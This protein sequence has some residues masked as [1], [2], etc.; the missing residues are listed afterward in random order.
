VLA[1]AIALYLSQTVEAQPTDDVGPGKAIRF[2]GVDDYIDLGDV[3][4][5]LALP[6]T[7]SVWVN[8][9][10]GSAYAYP[11][12]NSQDNLPLYNGVTFL[13]SAQGISI[14]Y[15][16]GRGEN[17]PSFRRGKSATIPDIA[18]RWVNLTAVM[19]GYYDMELFLNGVNVGGQYSGS[20][21]YPMASASPG[22]DAKIGYWLSNGIVSHFKGLMDDLRVF[23]RALSELEVKEQMCRKLTGN[24]SGLIGYWNFNELG[25]SYAK[26]NSPNGFDGQFQGNPTRV[27]SGAAIG[28]E[29][30]FLY[31][32]SWTGN[33]LEFGDIIVN[34]VTGSPEGI[35]IY[36]V[37]DIPS[38]TN[39]LDLG[40]IKNLYYGIFVAA[41]TS[42]SE[43]DIVDEL[44]GLCSASERYDNSEPQWVALD[45]FTFKGDRIEIVPYLVEEIE[46][47]DLGPDVRVCDVDSYHLVTNLVDF[48]ERSLRWS[49]GQ[50]STSIEVTQ[51]GIY[52]VEVSSACRIV[53]DTIIIDLIRSPIPFSLG[54]DE[55][56]CKIVPIHLQ[57]Q[58]EL[59]DVSYTWQDGSTGAYFDVTEFGTYWVA[60]KNFCG[61]ESDTIRIEEMRRDEVNPP[62]IIT[63]ND[64]QFNQYFVL[65]SDDQSPSQLFVH[66]RWGERVFESMNY[67]N[68]WDGGQLPP[69]IYYYQLFKECWGEIRGT[70]TISK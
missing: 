38:Q 24:E 60:A 28:D 69:G 57:P 19:R 37:H 7:I 5:D 9:D 27:F 52:A 11:I 18:G 26:D 47:V 42:G 12:F 2:D 55:M 41:S 31:P 23:D 35:Q 62:N 3:F 13:A 67:K 30:I 51:S 16:D 33:S 53:T 22:D 65:L 61:V 43:F 64:D 10:P 58:L 20:T 56:L 4:D 45:V 44:N 66:N 25:A 68:D 46:M 17:N 48:N 1:C 39:G 59:T 70:I 15:G 14:Q 8:V 6:V 49:T 21:S 29:S 63:P 54:K 36:Q 32:G 50:T 40:R 34:N